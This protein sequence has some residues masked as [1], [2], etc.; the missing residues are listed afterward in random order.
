MACYT[1]ENLFFERNMK[2]KFFAIFSIIF[3]ISA[4]GKAPTPT[5]APANTVIPPSLVP[6][7]T[8]T[9]L[10]TVTPACIS[11]EPTQ[12]DIDRATSFAGTTLPSSEWQQTYDASNGRVSVFWENATQSAVIFLETVIFPCGYEEP[13]LN[14]YFT[15]ENWKAVFQ[16]YETFESQGECRSETGVRLYLFKAVSQGYEYSVNY[17]AVN[18]TDNRVITLMMTFPS[19]SAALMS[20]YSAALFPV[21]PNCS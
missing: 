14:N 13:D 2:T 12:A 9:P 8:E 3:I 6:A 7:A 18:D 17:W 1:F 21:L 4:C 15:E 11:S 10:P 16:N 20:E 19:S 5:A